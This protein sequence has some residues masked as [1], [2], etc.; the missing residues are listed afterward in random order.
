MQPKWNCQ[1]NKWDRAPTRHLSSLNEASRTGIGSHLLE[2][3]SKVI[4]RE[5]PNNSSCCQGKLLTLHKQSARSDGWRKHLQNSLNREKSSW[6]LPKPSPPWLGVLDARRYPASYQWREVNTNRVV[7][8]SINK[9]VPPVRCTGAASSTRPVGVIN[10]H[11][12]LKPTPWDG[13]YRDASWM[14]KTWI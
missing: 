11:L 3:L 9:C 6:R 7:N 8:S 1:I 10:Q 5:P 4:L 2:L 12:D 14:T 13:T